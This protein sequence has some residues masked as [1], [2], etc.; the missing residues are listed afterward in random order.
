MSTP[1]QNIPLA[2]GGPPIIATRMIDARARISRDL[3]YPDGKSAAWWQVL[4]QLLNT[5]DE[6][7]RSGQ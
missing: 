6:T 7:K 1:P 5:Y 2:A 3:G 4:E